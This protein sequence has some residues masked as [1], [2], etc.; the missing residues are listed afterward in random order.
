MVGEVSVTGLWG[1]SVT[2][3]GVPV[4][5]LGVVSV[6]EL[7]TIPPTRLPPGTEPEPPKPVIPNPSNK[8]SRSPSPPS[9]KG[10]L[11]LGGGD[12]DNPL[13]RKFQP[14]SLL[15][16]LLALAN[17]RHPRLL[18]PASEQLLPLSHPQ[19]RRPRQPLPASSL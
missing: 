7:N 17:R 3:L 15:A 9:I 13:P 2:G 8:P 4:V 5:G 14:L 12:K 16:A 19:T 18:L 1:S 6:T 10:I 11:N